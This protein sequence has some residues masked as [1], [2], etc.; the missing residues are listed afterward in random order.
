MRWGNQVRRLFICASMG[1]VSV[2]SFNIHYLA[3]S[4]EMKRGRI[5]AS[6]YGTL[7]TR[8]TK[9]SIPRRGGT[10]HNTRMLTCRKVG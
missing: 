2:S 6:I 4:L 10:R 5:I 8:T 7:S 9:A 3:L 1:L